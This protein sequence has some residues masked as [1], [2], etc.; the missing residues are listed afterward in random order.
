MLLESGSSV[1]SITSSRDLRSMEAS[2]ATHCL[3]TKC[4]ARILAGTTSLR[5]I[6]AELQSAV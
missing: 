3:E 6:P 5:Q 2:E 4:L 1:T